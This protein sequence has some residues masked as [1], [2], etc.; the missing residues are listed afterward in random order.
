[1]N[2]KKRA[3]FILFSQ[4][5]TFCLAQNNTISIHPSVGDTID[6]SEKIKYV[7]FEEIK[8]ENYL[9]SVISASGP[10]T[11]I[12]YYK[13]TDTLRL[14]II[15]K[16][17]AVIIYNI[18]RLN[19]YYNSSGES[20]DPD[21]IR[22]TLSDSKENHAINKK[23]LTPNSHEKEIFKSERGQKT[24]PTEWDKLGTIHTFPGQKY[25]PLKPTPT[26][27]R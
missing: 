11:S 8:N 12:T 25:V 10:D 24:R 23:N 7:L 4:T 20:A 27:H 15:Q 17:I 5:T 22:N 1:M 14:K 6:T 9:F 13:K 16:E 21:F 3:F 2:F 26:L 19:A 18:E